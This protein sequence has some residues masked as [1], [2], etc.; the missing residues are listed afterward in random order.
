MQ[1]YRVVFHTGA[2]ETISG[3]CELVE[4]GSRYLFL[5]LDAV[6][7]FDKRDVLLIEEEEQRGGPVLDGE[8]A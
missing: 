2:D 4:E 1:S 6:R 3:P 5:S 7:A 8:A